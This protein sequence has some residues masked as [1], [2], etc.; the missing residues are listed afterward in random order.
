MALKKIV[1]MWQYS[2][3]GDNFRGTPGLD[4]CCCISQTNQK[5]ITEK[6]VQPKS[7]CIDKIALYQGPAYIAEQR[8]NMIKNK[9]KRDSFVDTD[10]VYFLPS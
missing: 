6:D 9:Q 4:W 1:F 7:N 2:A 3:D 10:T 8:N 5:Y